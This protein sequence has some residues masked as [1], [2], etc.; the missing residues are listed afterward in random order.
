M[1]KK[2]EQDIL[3]TVYTNVEGDTTYWGES[4][5][6]YLAGRRFANE[7]ISNWEQ[8]TIET[9]ASQIP[10]RWRELWKKLSSAA[11]GGKTVLAAT[12]AYATP[13]DF[14]EPSSYVR[15]I[16]SSG[17]ST[18]YDVVPPEKIS[19]LIDTTGNWCYFTGNSKDGFTLNFNPKLTLTAGH[20]IEYEYYKTASS[21]TATT[22][23]SEMRDDSYITEYVTAMFYKDEDLDLYNIHMKKAIARL[24]QMIA[25]NQTGYWQVDE[26]IDETLAN[27]NQEGFGV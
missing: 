23:K 6:E 25:N 14:V 15:T 5:D 17:N 27:E 9:E 19:M 2:T 4:D 18:W 22:S 13:S 11:D 26:K 8:A 21:F 10:V 12:Y 20:T 24:N 16:D 7:A 3:N 1:L